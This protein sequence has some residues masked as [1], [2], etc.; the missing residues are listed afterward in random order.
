MVI[1]MFK[2]RD[3]VKYGA[4][5]VCRITEISEKSFLGGNAEYY[6]LKSTSRDDYFF[7]PTQNESLV[8]KLQYLLSR[9][10]IYS[11]IGDIPSCS[12]QWEPDDKARAK[13]YEDIFAKADR[14]RIVGLVHTLRSKRNELSAKGKK[15]HVIDERALANAEKIVAE[16]FSVVLGIRKA[17][18][19]GFI[20][21]A[22][23]ELQ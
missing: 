23:A 3:I 22:L 19:E 7:V 10:E 18:V 8:S 20:S 4:N 11:L 16:E 14:Q 2:V 21:D 13:E 9:E 6:V 12:F 17:D 5:G 15:L 1:N